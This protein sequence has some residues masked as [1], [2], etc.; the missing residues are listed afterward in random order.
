MAVISGHISLLFSSCTFHKPT[1]EVNEVP[2]NSPTWNF[3]V[4]GFGTAADAGSWQIRELLAHN[5]HTTNNHEAE[6]SVRAKAAG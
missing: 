1:I 6:P 4:S 2:G 3:E 5:P